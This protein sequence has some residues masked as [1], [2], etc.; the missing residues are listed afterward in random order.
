MSN[1]SRTSW[2]KDVKEQKERKNVE[3]E[4]WRK[5]C[6]TFQEYCIFS[7]LSNVLP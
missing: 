1:T 4:L 2:L 5:E 3:P 7:E 6:Q